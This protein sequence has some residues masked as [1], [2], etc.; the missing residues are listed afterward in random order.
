MS[1][2]VET[3]PG[4]LPM[5]LVSSIIGKTPRSSRRW[6]KRNNCGVKVGRFWYLSTEKLLANFIHLTESIEDAQEYT[7]YSPTPSRSCH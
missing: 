2:K 4:N 3:M 5:S 6:V 1:E 7:T